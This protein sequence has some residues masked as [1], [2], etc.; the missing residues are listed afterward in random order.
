GVVA[1]EHDAA[2]VEH[3]E[4]LDVVVAVPYLVPQDF[5]GLRDRVGG[6]AVPRPHRGVHDDDRRAHGLLGRRVADGGGG[7]GHLGGCSGRGERG[8][9]GRLGG[10]R[11]LHVRC[12]GACC[13]GERRGGFPGGPVSFPVR[14][15]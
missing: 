10:L 13:V 7:F 15:L 9:R 11:G 4:H 14:H 6:A 2:E 5:E 1:V 8:G 12:S 3:V